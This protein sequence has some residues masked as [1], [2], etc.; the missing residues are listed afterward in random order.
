[1]KK[2]KIFRGGLSRRKTNK[3]NKKD[4]KAVKTDQNREKERDRDNQ[5]YNKTTLKTMIGLTIINNL[6][7]SSNRQTNIHRESLINMR[8]NENEHSQE[9]QETIF[10]AEMKV[11]GKPGLL[12]EI[13]GT[14]RIK[15]IIKDT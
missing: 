10:Y 13:K 11:K 5:F 2:K 8:P 9:S 14:R 12:R 15:F 1:M 6:S 3:I 7:E 4:K